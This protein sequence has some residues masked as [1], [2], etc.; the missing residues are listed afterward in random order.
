MAE[1]LS[2]ILRF[3]AN[4]RKLEVEEMS[5]GSVDMLSDCGPVT[6][7]LSI[8]SN[9]FVEMSQSRQESQDNTMIDEGESS[10]TIIKGFAQGY[11]NT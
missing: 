6:G 11:P 5:T 8:Q 2:T 9:G 7:G 1:V 10:F 3:F 4:V